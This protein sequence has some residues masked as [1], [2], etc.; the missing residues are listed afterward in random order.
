MGLSDQEYRRICARLGREPN[1]TELGMFA[2]LWSEHCAYKHSRHWLALLPT[3]GERVV[4]GPGENA[5]A[6]DLGD[7][8]VACWKMESHN[9]PSAIE[10]FQGAATGVGGIVRDILAMGARPVALL[11]SLHFGPPG[12]GRAAYLIDGV[13]SGIAAYGNCIGVPTVGG[14]TRFSEAYALNPLVNVM[15]VG[16]APRGRLAR[17]VAEGVGNPVLLVGNRTGRDGIHG[18]TFASEELGQ[19]SLSRRPAV[20]V[21]DPFTEKLLIEACLEAWGSGALVGMQDLGAAGLTSAAAESAARAG[22]GMEIDLDRVPRREQGMTPYEVMLSESQERM[23]LIARRGRE[24][25]VRRIMEKWGLA[26]SLVGRV[27][28][29]GRLR[30]LE[31]GRV[32]AD[33]PVSALAQEAP[34]YNPRAL[35]PS[36]LREAWTATLPSPPPPSSWPAALNRALLRLLGGP[37][38]GSR[39]WVYEQY[40]HMVQ[41]GTALPPGAD[42][43]VLMLKGSRRALAVCADG[44]G[45]ACY[46]DPRRG[47]A[48]VVAEAARNLVCVGARPIGIT[49]CLNFGSPEKPS[50]YWQFQ[51]AVAGMAEACRALNLPVTGGN[52]SFYN[53]T[54]GRAVHPTPVI[55]AVG[56]LEDISRLVRPGFD[57]PGHL[58][59]LLGDRAP[60]ELGGSQYLETAFG[61]LLGRPPAVNLALESRLQ[62]LCLDAAAEGLL[63]SAHDCSDGGLAV[64][65]AECCLMAA[66][67]AAGAEVDLGTLRAGTRVDAW[68]FGERPSRVVASVSPGALERVVGLARARD[69]PCRVLGVVGPGRLRVRAR[70]ELLLDVEVEELRQAWE[71]ALAAALAGAGQGGVRQVG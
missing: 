71:V 7:G 66:P 61:A 4:Q 56:L 31:G 45:R 52:V 26:A 24:E 67:Q 34:M 62:A 70:G 15:C 38:L 11:D 64:A 8:F 22:T 2:V 13:V 32:V 20:Q 3:Q 25:E 33:V 55:G 44:N 37:D 51:Q 57:S 10:P 65:L 6:V 47:G 1:L 63:A 12:P 18:C 5:G 40:D 36:Y 60:G 50:V 29:D 41:T 30:V 42:A 53:E 54:S 59:L 17:G 69:V 27:T 28:G 9:H 58:V 19:G 46:L 23:L 21:G 48:A 14:E 49:N 35:R 16:L 39:R 43:A 68:L